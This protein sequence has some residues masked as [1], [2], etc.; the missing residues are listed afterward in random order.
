MNLKMTG[1]T[2]ETRE[3]IGDKTIKNSFTMLME[4]L[5]TDT[6]R[7][8]REKIRTEDV[9]KNGLLLD[10][11]HRETATDIEQLRATKEVA[12][13]SQTAISRSPSSLSKRSPLTQM[14]ITLRTTKTHLTWKEK[15]RDTS[16]ITEDPSKVKR[17]SS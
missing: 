1:E 7:R 9:H 11:D 4:H 12:V 15:S 16:K 8:D 10:P 3:I 5:F 17:R 2:N 14:T 13:P 6:M